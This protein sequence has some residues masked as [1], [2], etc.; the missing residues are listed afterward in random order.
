M[1]G[2]QTSILKKLYVFVLFQ[3]GGMSFW[4]HRR[5]E[6]GLSACPP[7]VRKMLTY[8]LPLF[9]L[10]PNVDNKTVAR[11]DLTKESKDLYY[12]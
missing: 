9:H 11:Q 4:L 1:L 5:W 10:S 2:I 3:G 8:G 7:L 12:N 6:N